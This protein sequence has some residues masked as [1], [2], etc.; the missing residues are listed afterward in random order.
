MLLEPT[1]GSVV[2]ISP[3]NLLT[4]ERICRHITGSRYFF[5]IGKGP[6]DVT[7]RK[8]YKELESG[9]RDISKKLY[10]KSPEQKGGRRTYVNRTREIRVTVRVANHPGLITENA[11]LCIAR[12]RE[13][14]RIHEFYVSEEYN[15]NESSTWAEKR[16]AGRFVFVPLNNGTFSIRA[17]AE[18]PAKTLSHDSIEGFY[19][20]IRENHEPGK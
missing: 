13:T 9:Y 4:K 18:Q 17:L 8:L 3:T 5:M 16:I 19:Q 14:K 6:V 2:A 11:F 15:L 7:D 12:N 1:F 20:R 10:E